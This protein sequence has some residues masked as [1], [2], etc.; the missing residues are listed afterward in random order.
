MPT[1]SA[2]IVVVDDEPGLV[3]LI[4]FFL[5]GHG[6]EVTTFSHPE[7]ALRAFEAGIEADLL[8]VDNKMPVMSGVEL[9]ERVSA[10]RPDLPIVFASAEPGLRLSMGPVVSKP[11]TEIELVARVREALEARE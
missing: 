4:R 5:A 3:E 8:L 10:L 11:F 7:D 9:A 1:K 2:R 6:Y